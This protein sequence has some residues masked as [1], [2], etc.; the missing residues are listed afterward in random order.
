MLS[1]THILCKIP[2]YSYK[3]IIT[4]DLL[5]LLD[6]RQTGAPVSDVGVYSVFLFLGM[7]GNVLRSFRLVRSSEGDAPHPREDR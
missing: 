4:L 2:I 3:S 1:N 7:C 6:L 5:A